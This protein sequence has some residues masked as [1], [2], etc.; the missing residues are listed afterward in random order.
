MT[1]RKQQVK[2]HFIKIK[3]F[4][5]QRTLSSEMTQ[6]TGW[7]Q[8]F[9]KHKSVLRVQYLNYI[10]IL[11]IQKPKTNKPGQRT[12]TTFPQRRNTNDQ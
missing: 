1:E 12:E 11:T 5:Q 10:K 9:S 3:N 6:P 2:W 7:E 8:I 4:S